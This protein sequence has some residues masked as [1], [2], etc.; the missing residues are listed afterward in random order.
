MAGKISD[1]N[2]C[3]SAC[4]L[5][6]LVGCDNAEPIRDIAYFQ[7]IGLEKTLAQLKTCGSQKKALLEKKDAEGLDRY[8][9]SRQLTN[10]HTGFKFAASEEAKNLSSRI[11]EFKNVRSQE[12]VKAL[13]QKILG[14]VEA[15]WDGIQPLANDWIRVD[16]QDLAYAVRA[17]EQSAANR[18][19]NLDFASWGKRR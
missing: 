6:V 11:G 16:G 18:S 8:A 7:G 17:I 4:A 5:L 12:E 1:L 9:K 2:T 19:S 15:R 10:C 14:D 13:K 3:I